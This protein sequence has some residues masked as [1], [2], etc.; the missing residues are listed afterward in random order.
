MCVNA[1]LSLRSLWLV[2]SAGID[3]GPPGP[4]VQDKRFEDGW[5]LIFVEFKFPS[6]LF[7]F[8]S[9]S[10]L[11]LLSLNTVKFICLMVLVLF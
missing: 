6:F 11:S 5:M 7:V 10:L 2:A 9:K 8:K 3:S 1:C 4:R